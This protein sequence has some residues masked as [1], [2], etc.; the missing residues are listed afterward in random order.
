MVSHLRYQ[1]GPSS[2]QGY[3]CLT[4]CDF[5]PEPHLADSVGANER[6]I[7]EGSGYTTFQNSANSGVKWYVI[8]F[9]HQCLRCMRV[10][11][12]HVGAETVPW[13]T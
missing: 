12:P 11:D 10:D 7:Q 6:D 5:V 13:V 9:V 4:N 2:S 3:I 8:S 1:G